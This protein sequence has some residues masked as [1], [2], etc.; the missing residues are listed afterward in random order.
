MTNLPKNLFVITE[1]SLTTEFVITE[2]DFEEINNEKLLT[3]SVLSA[4]ESEGT[5]LDVGSIIINWQTEI[6]LSNIN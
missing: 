4:V 5:D 2:I 1:C 6:F 3:H